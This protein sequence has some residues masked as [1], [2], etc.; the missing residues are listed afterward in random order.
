MAAFARAVELGAH[1]IELDVHL[2]ADGVPVVIHDFT[3]DATTDGSGPV[4]SMPLAQLKELD[5]G[6]SFAPAFAGEPIPT[7]AEVLETF[8]HRLFLN[9]ELK[10]TSPGD[11]GLER[12]VIAQVREH[13][14]DRNDRVLLSSFNPPHSLTP[15]GIVAGLV[16]APRAPPGAP[17]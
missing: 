6:S 1:G 9:I 14:L 2:S 3:V 12:A 7:L 4:S 15:S 17:S 8:G 13:G 11:N 5:A 10:T 16:R